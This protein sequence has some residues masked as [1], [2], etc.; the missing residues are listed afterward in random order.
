[1]STA[2]E[3][4]F[5]EL[6]RKNNR[7]VKYKLSRRA[8][9]SA[10]ETEKPTSPVEAVGNSSNGGSSTAESIRQTIRNYWAID[11]EED[12]EKSKRPRR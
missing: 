3:D 4:L 2:E 5:E 11:D 8:R 6:L 9:P 7:A 1:M 10:A 12:E